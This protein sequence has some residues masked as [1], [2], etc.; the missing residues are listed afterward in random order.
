MTPGGD[1]V[2]RR[3]LDHWER[4]EFAPKLDHLHPDVVLV[5]RVSGRGF[6]GLDAFANCIDEAYAEAGVERP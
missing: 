1:D 3:L 6:E 4:G 5:N 2:V